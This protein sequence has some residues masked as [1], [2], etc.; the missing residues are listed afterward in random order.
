MGLV[1]L[2]ASG[3]ANIPPTISFGTPGGNLGNSHIYTSGGLTVPASGFTAANAP[4]ALFGKN[5]GGDEVGLGLVNDPSGDNEI[6]YGMGYVQLDVSALFGLVSSIT[7]STNSTTDG[8][9]WS[10]FGSNVSGSYSGVALLSG[11]NQNSATLP[12]FGTY[13]YY[14]FVSTS[15]R[16]EKL[17]DRRVDHDARTGA[18]DL[19]DDA[20]GLRRSRLCDQAP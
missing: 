16:E 13:N 6:Y 7:F 3:A 5:A 15:T 10:I 4:T 14:D 20:A 8:E 18:V 11:T 2:A 9:Q 19:G 1:A 12:N 17:P